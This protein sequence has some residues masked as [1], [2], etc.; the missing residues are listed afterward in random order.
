M[1]AQNIRLPNIRR[2]FVPDIGHTIIDADL[3]GADA[4]VV[5]W[6]AEDQKLKQAFRQGK[7]IHIINARDTWPER[8]K[9]MTDEEIK[10]TGKS[11]G[12]YY[13]IKRAVHATNYYAS[14]SALVAA[15]GWSEH[16][17]REFQYRWFQIHP[18]IREWHKRVE[19]YL[20]GSQCWNCDN[21]DVVIGSRCKDCGVRLGRTVKNKFGF[22][23]IFFGRN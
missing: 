15:L 5:A 20:D 1:V 18:E 12:M 13:E 22:R 6:E 21:L 4:Q 14:P 19:R 10:E 9:D 23:R 16:K 3:A 2:I 17:A 11:G 7:K 8:T